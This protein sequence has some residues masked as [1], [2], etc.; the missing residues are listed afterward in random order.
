MPAAH[1]WS[2]VVARHQPGGMSRRVQY[3]D[4]QGAVRFSS[5]N[6]AGIDVLTV[7]YVADGLVARAD[8]P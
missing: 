1:D 3:R 4:R 6:R 5:S 8:R 7:H 2:H